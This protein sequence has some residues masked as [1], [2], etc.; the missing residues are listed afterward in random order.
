VTVD[1]AKKVLPLPALLH[2]EGLGDHAKKSAPC[3]FHDDDR[4]SF[5]V[6]KNGSGVFRWKCF[7]GCGRG[8]EID[9]LEKR[10]AISRSDATKLFI[11]MAGGRNGARPLPKHLESFDW[12]RCVD[13][14]TD[15]HLERLA[16]WRGYSGEF[17]SWLKENGFVGLYDDHIAFPL[18]DRS[19]KV[20]A[21]HVRQKDASWRYVPKGT[22]THPLVIG[23]LFAGDTVHVFESQWDAFA[24]MDASGERSGIIVTRG[25]SN[26]AL[27]AGLIPKG[28]N[29]CLWTQTDEAGEKWQKDICA[30]TKARVK[31]AKIPAPQK[32]LNEWTRAG[33]TADDLLA[34]MM[35][36]EIL[37]EPE[38][39]LIEFKS[40]LQLQNFVPPP[41]IMMVGDCHI[42]KGSVFVIGGAP[43][44]GKSRAL[45]AL[46]VAGA[47]Q[48]DWFGL[49]THRRF[50]VMIIQTENGLFRLSKEFGELNCDALESY[51]RVCPPP[52]YGLC[53]RR[54]DFRAQLSA[55]I[56]DF[57]PEV[58]GFDPWNAA[59]REQDSREYLDTF[60]ALKSVLPLGED[61]PALVI[62]AHTRKPKADERTSG[63][64][65]LNLLAG[66]YV[67]GS[68][69]RTVF[70]MQAASDDTTDNR[71]VWTCCK[72]NDGELGARSAWE[73]RNGLFAPVT[74]FDFEKFDAP[75]Q[76]KREVICED[77]VRSVFENGALTKAE[78]RKLLEQATD[79]SR[80]A[81]YYALDPDGRFAKH[82]NYSEGKLV[83]K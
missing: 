76:D 48:S 47:T 1:K 62:V 74:D 29:V 6:Y 41:G 12:S 71:I 50:K 67:L 7:A 63:R 15:E 11:E 4:N 3:P 49:K 42:T 23:E 39:P 30:N 36:A 40:P 64:A 81:C 69:P 14:F 19:G 8:D 58:V 37:R 75:D 10:R 22:K 2:C 13:A 82:L 21:A 57:Q 61:A 66:S 33:G 53:F 32:D 20:I 78:A 60:D 79:A 44:I 54:D 65:L 72:N 52:P 77:D 16:D 80:S 28:S 56:A 51:V 24:F 43:G 26:G 18:H 34:A 38:R 68:V 27:V 70:V 83:W 46:A 5:S 9:F 35:N 25:A 31:R 73:R 55:A 45:V 17:C 59:A